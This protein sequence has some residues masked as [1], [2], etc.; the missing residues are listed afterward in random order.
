MQITTQHNQIIYEIK[1][2]HGNV[3]FSYE[4]EFRDLSDL[5]LTG[6]NLSGVVAEGLICMDAKFVNANLEKANL[7]MM[8]ACYSDF[9]NANLA[10]SDLRGANCKGVIFQKT[11]LRNAN[12]GKD[13]MGGTVRLQGT[14]LENADIDGVIWQETEYDENTIFPNGF[15]PKN[16]GMIFVSERPTHLFSE[17]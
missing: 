9:T 3:L 6:A 8:M 17:Y 15:N 14:N 10:K 2:T 13:N 1:D 5:D 4:N 16:Y 7:Y 12:L 11:L